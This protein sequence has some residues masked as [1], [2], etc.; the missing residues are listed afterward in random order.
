MF[1][2]Q[3]PRGTCSRLQHDTTTFLGS[4]FSSYYVDVSV[5]PQ[6][7]PQE[8]STRTTASALRL[9]T[10]QFASLDENATTQVHMLRW[11]RH[12]ALRK[13]HL[14]CRPSLSA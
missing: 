3:K 7:F 4:A 6:P 12:L 1:S 2:S 10:R 11:Q 8:C 5:R 13:V 9:K 14:N